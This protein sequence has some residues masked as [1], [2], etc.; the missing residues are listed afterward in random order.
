MTPERWARAA[1]LYESA[2]AVDPAGR[3]AF[4]AQ[5]CRDDSALRREVESLLVQEQAAV[6]V[7]HPVDVAAA[8][9]LGDA[10]GLQPNDRVGPYVVAGLL[11]AG[12]MGQVYRARDTKLQR[13]VALKILPDSFIHDP[14]RL[15][16]FTRE[17]QVLASLNHPNIGAI[18][19]FEDSGAVHALVLELVEGPT[20]ADRIARGPLPVDEAL[21][22][23]RQIAEA[24]EAAHEHGIV[25]R[26]LKPAN[27]K[28]RDDGAVK[29]LDF[30]LAK[31][32]EAGG[33]GRADEANVPNASNALSMSPTI[34]SPAMTGMGV[35]LGTAAYMSP[36]QAKGKP[37]DK[38]SDIWAFGCVLFE[39]LTGK[40]AFDGDDVSDTLAAVLRGEPDWTLLARRVSPHITDLV[41]ACLQKD[42]K[43][44]LPAISAARFL[45]DRD[46]AP[47]T[48]PDRSYRTAI[49]I[50][51]AATAIGATLVAVLV[52]LSPRVARQ[53][54][55]RFELPLGDQLPLTAGPSPDLAVSP[56][57]TSVVYSIAPDDTGPGLGRNRIVLRRLDRLEP[58]T[59]VATT[60]LGSPFFS[61]D[62]QWI[63]FMWG[64]GELRKVPIT[65][66]PPVTINAVG[67]L[68]GASWGSDNRIVYSSSSDPG[69]FRVSADG[70]TPERLTTLDV[71]RGESLHGWPDVL[72]GARAVLFT[73]VFA[74]AGG[75]S[76]SSLIAA[77][78][79]RTRESKV[80]I[81][82][83]AQ[84]HFVEPDYLVYVA[85][86]AIMAVRFDPERLEVTGEP[87]SV[88]S[89]ARK[90][91][92]SVAEFAVSRNGVLVYAPTAVGGSTA[93]PPRTLVWVDRTGRE[94]PISAAPPGP[95]IYPRLS[96]DATRVAVTREAVNSR[97]ENR[98]VW[99]L[100]LVRQTFNRLTSGSAQENSAVWVD[101]DTIV[102]GS[103]R[104]GR[105]NLYRQR[106][107]TTGT[108][109]R[110]TT[111][112]TN[113]VPTGVGPRGEVVFWEVAVSGD[114]NL[115]ALEPAGQRQSRPVAASSAVETN[116]DVSPDGNW[117][118]YE[119]NASGEF[120]VFVQPFRDAE[121]AHVQISTSGGR[122][123]R[124]APSGRE[125][126]FF[127]ER[128]ELMAAPVQ[129][130][131]TFTAGTPTKVLDAKYINDAGNARNYDVARDGRFLMIKRPADGDK[132]RTDH[133]VVVLNWREEL[134]PRL[135]AK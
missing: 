24:L 85:G 82:G 68:N 113:Q 54:V 62:G 89:V 10:P 64:G 58:S 51:A 29:V 59:I 90:R 45:L 57:G 32:T 8:A 117:L 20:L 14:D 39:M 93:G 116:G 18:Y 134:D 91:L 56:D 102:F 4:L 79:L 27:I 78:D 83:G 61:P 65:G 132:P 15:A 108:F 88:V 128:G 84:A 127:N 107:D 135:A 71:Q 110:L 41:E 76:S 72:P 63:G 98:A 5:A 80:L 43:Q 67:V 95:Y 111:H 26:D 112:A 77:L 130:S 120:H 23:A 44:R 52:L 121:G 66:G 33:A 25:H 19:G 81:R 38:R 101:D 30:G 114:L 50:G 47:R 42:R 99:I 49:T 1:E 7:D 34:M 46:P 48:A 119:S 129:A 115:M 31:L 6:L 100:D 118:A 125:L 17:A 94:E 3:A 97:D 73:A 69:L 13:D 37:A 55:G 133:L 60:R 74:A 9:V 2:L 12:G 103:R 126:F 75:D 21:A 124:W 87:L 28:V 22:I 86:D 92:L 40:R 35:I 36:E 16:R 96:P 53:Q 131:S 106:V 123:P 109:E 11:G 70:G 122:Q 105:S 104:S